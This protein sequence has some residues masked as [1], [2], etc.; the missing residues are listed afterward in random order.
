MTDERIIEIE[1]DL[2]LDHDEYLKIDDL[3][4]QLRFLRK[5]ATHISIDIGCD[6]DG[7]RYL[8]VSSHHI[9][10]ETKEEQTQRQDEYIRSQQMVEMNQ[11]ENERTELKRLK[12]KYE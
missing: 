10:Q 4:S 8:D 2:D 5:T 3:I 9:R 7:D 12:L 11:I 1:S 6:R